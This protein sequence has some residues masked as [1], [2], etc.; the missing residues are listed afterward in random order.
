MG[1]S[2]LM[3]VLQQEARQQIEMLWRDAEEAVAQKRAEIALIAETAEDDYRHE[4]AEKSAQ[5]RERIL[6]LAR[7]EVET[8]LLRVMKSCSDRL[9]GRSEAL[10][11]DLAVRGGAALFTALCAELPDRCWQTVICAPGDLPFARDRFP[12]AEIIP[13]PSVGGGVI[14]STEQ[15]RIHVDNSL[16]G[17]L[18]RSWSDLFP[19]VL[20]LVNS[21]E[22][23]HE[24]H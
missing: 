3:G 5:E 24:T 2:E 10:L 23:D 16:A 19:L 21:Q 11:A 7:R 12:D 18:R 22:G 8:E 9:L 13:D 14:V 4:V 20:D 15:G 17:R 6:S 1:E